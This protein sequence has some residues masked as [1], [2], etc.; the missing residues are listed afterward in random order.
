MPERLQSL[1]PVPLQCPACPGAPVLSQHRAGLPL[2]G[3]L[4]ELGDTFEF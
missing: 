2:G 3:L 4:Q 1:A